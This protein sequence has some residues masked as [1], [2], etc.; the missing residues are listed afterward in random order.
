MTRLSAKRELKQEYEA[1]S[2]A[3]KFE[4]EKKRFKRM[5]TFFEQ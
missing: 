1:L 2:N 4:Y 3:E 5:E